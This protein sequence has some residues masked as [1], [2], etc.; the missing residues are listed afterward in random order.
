MNYQ[1]QLY[2]NF[3]QPLQIGSPTQF[4]SLSDL[5]R[6]FSLILLNNNVAVS[7]PTPQY[8][9]M[10]NVAGMHIKL[11][12]LNEVGIKLICLYMLFITVF[13]F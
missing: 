8:P 10:I 9:N 6:N 3:F 7:K 2:K 13:S 1:E 12:K 5:Y 4:P 11:Q